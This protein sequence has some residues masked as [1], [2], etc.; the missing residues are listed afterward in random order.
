MPSFAASTS[1]PDERRTP[2]RR[3]DQPGPCNQQRADGVERSEDPGRRL[4]EDQALDPDFDEAAV[5]RGRA[6]LDTQPR[7][8]GGER[9]FLAQPGLHGDETD[10]GQVQAAE[11]QRVDPGP[12]ARAV[13]Q[14]D[15]DEAADHERHHAE[16]EHENDVGEQA[17]G[18]RLQGT[19]SGGAGRSLAPT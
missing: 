5:V 15:A 6:G 14:E 10:G 11:G 2:D 12:D 3:V 16:V 4:V 1:R 17:V 8:E 13:A 9:A 18:H 7:L 19:G